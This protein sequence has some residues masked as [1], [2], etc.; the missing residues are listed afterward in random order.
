M[1]GTTTLRGRELKIDFKQTGEIHE[2]VCIHDSY[3][4]LEGIDEFGRLWYAD[5]YCCDG[6]LIEI[7]D[8]EFT[9][10]RDLNERRLLKDIK[11]G[12]NKKN[13]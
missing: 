3:E 4:L 1:I 7:V 13:R 2:Q 11:N 5:G 12:K 9:L 6:E 10:F 8:E